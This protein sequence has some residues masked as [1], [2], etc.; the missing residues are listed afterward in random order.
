MPSMNLN[1]DPD[2][3]LPDRRARRHVRPQYMS[4]R[5]ARAWESTGRVEQAYGDEPISERQEDLLEPVRLSEIPVALPPAPAR[6]VAPPLGVLAVLWQARHCFI[7]GRLG[8]C[9]HREPRV[10]LAEF[11]AEEVAG[12]IE[13]SQPVSPAR[14]PPQQETAVVEARRATR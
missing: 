8:Q 7:C 9:G 2:T 14:K 11:R 6:R 1:P 10:D 13:A 3:Y 4:P 12:R 5:E